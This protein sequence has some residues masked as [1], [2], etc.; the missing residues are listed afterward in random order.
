MKIYFQYARLLGAS[1]RLYYVFQ[2]YVLEQEV[3]SED[4]AF[5]SK[6]VTH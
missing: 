4:G 1:V 3:K 6:H 5:A 2:Y